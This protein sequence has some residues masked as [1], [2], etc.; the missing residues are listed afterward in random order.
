MATPRLRNKKALKHYDTEFGVV[1]L[2]IVA[3]KTM[4]NIMIE[5]N[6]LE[7]RQKR[8]VSA[9]AEPRN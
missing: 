8:H 4:R 5:A 2:L 7:P 3:C 9:R 1:E 6:I